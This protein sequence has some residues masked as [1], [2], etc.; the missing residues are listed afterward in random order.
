MAAYAV[1]V[2]GELELAVPVFRESIVGL[3]RAGHRMALAITAG[4]IADTIAPRDRNAA[5]DLLCVAESGAIAD[6]NV[7]DNVYF[8]NLQALVAELDLGDLARRRAEYS[9]MSYEDAVA[10]VLERLDQLV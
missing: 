6:V 5:V 4:T 10:L 8:T 2:R 7:R 9:T 3:D 1:A